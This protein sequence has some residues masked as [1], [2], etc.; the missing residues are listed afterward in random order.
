MLTL[1]GGRCILHVQRRGIEGRLL[2]TSGWLVTMKLAH[3]PSGL[4]ILYTRFDPLSPLFIPV[5]PVPNSFS[6]WS[7]LA[8]SSSQDL[9]MGS[10]QRRGD[11]AKTSIS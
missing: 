8:M 2:K 9:G 1:I 6:A 7:I 11:L 5:C 4:N 3:F 10:S